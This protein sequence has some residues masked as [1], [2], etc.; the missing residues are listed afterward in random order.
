[1][2]RGVLV[3]CAVAALAVL[4]TGCSAEPAPRATP[5][6]TPPIASRPPSAQTRFDEVARA[7]MAADAHPT[8]R[9]FAAALRQ[10]G[11]EGVETTPDR[12][13]VDLDVPSVQFAVREGARCVVGQ[14]GPGTAYRSAVADAVAGRCLVGAS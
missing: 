14:Y 6:A 5:T 3:G 13:A 12:T 2:H 7:V 11:F 10:A 9:A 4:L 8:G 1:M